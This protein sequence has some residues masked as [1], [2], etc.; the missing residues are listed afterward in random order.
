MTKLFL[1]Y[2][3]KH[4]FIVGLKDEVKNIVLKNEKKCKEIKMGQKKTRAIGRTI[5]MSH[6]LNDNYRRV[7][8][9]WEYHL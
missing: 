8:R 2:A 6:Y 3:G 4:C 1:N 9:R 7:R 5:Q